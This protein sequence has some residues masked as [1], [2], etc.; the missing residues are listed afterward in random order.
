MDDYPA[1]DPIPDPDIAGDIRYSTL[2]DYMSNSREMREAATSSL[3]QAMWA[4]S[5]ALMGGFM[6]GPVGG[7]V[8]GIAG[9]LV[10]FARSPSYDGMLVQLCQLN[11]EQKKVL[12]MRVGE[13][14]IAAGATAQGM[15]TA[16]A[17]RDT[18][19][20]YASQRSVRESLW[21]ACIESLQQ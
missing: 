8:G 19:I 10:G 18:L 16:T 4:G 20:S 11:D 3:K 1:S 21:N 13:V 2:M 7:L 6:L 5:G 9:S 15:D 14:L 12:L 17:F